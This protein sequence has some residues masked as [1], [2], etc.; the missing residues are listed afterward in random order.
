MRDAGWARTHLDT[1]PSWRGRWLIRRGDGGCFAAGCLWPHPGPGR[2]ADL[3]PRRQ[4]HDII[5]G[6]AHHPERQHSLP[7]HPEREGHALADNPHL[8]TITA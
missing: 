5:R 1:K 2:D 3:S 4:A 6:G 7:A 8:R